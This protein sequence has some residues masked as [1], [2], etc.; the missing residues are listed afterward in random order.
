VENE[1]D[2][3][4]DEESDDKFISGFIEK[5]SNL[6][7]QSSFN[8]QRESLKFK[9]NSES[10]KIG[11][12]SKFVNNSEFSKTNSNERNSNDSIEELWKKGIVVAVNSRLDEMKKIKNDI[13]GL[14]ALKVEDAVKKETGKFKILLES[15]KD[16]MM[17]SNRE[18]LNQKQREISFI[19]DSKIA[20][21]KK[22]STNLNNIIFQ[23][24]SSKQQQQEMLI[25]I[26]KN[27][28]DAKK[29][30]A[31]L[32]IEVNS[33]L[34]KSKS[35]AQKFIDDAKTQ[36]ES[37]D[38]RI[39]KTL[40]FEK[41]I[42]QGLLH[43]AE[44][45]IENLAIQKADEL[46]EEL[47]LK[48]NKLKSIEKDINLDGLGQKIKILDQFKKEFL[49]NMDDNLQKI[50]QAIEKINIQNELVSKEIGEKTIIIDAKI[51]ELTKFEKSIANYFEKEFSNKKTKK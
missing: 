3:E 21:I 37:L 28:D 44:I 23:I 20:E 41:N 33:E 40:E 38:N 14:I 22:E 35:Q 12:E 25:E 8:K 43:E 19:I 13:D 24:E 4:N 36:L 49:N 1:S 34:I 15:Q 9:Q 6:N 16:L 51:D 48:L 39:N 30:K 50:N 32:I 7:N 31:Q 17:A 26:K 29:T 47:E 45:K 46:L 5:H 10:N 42:A 2:L 11:S 18:A 27:L